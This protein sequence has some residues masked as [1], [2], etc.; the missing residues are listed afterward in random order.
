M[1]VSE[2]IEQCLQRNTYISNKKTRDEELLV[3]KY[4]KIT[5]HLLIK[6]YHQVCTN[7]KIHS[8]YIKRKIH[9]N[10][11]QYTKNNKIIYDHVTPFLKRTDSSG[12]N[13]SFGEGFKDSIKNTS[14]TVLFLAYS[15]ALVRL[16]HS[17]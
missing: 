8:S 3:T 6:C 4:I 5:K 9:K 7:F 10:N 1:H 13:C 15:G 12:S 17:N 16:F 14:K 2:R 11:L